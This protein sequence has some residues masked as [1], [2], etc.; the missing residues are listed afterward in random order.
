[1]ILTSSIDVGGWKEFFTGDGAPLCAPGRIFGRAS[2]LVMSGPGFRGRSCETL[3]VE[4]VPAVMRTRM[5]RSPEPETIRTAGRRTHGKRP[6]GTS[7]EFIRPDWRISFRLRVAILFRLCMRLNS[8]GSNKSSNAH[9][10]FVAQRYRL[11]AA[12]FWIHKLHKES[13]EWMS[14][15]GSCKLPASLAWSGGSLVPDSIEVLSKKPFAV[16][17]STTGHSCRSAG[18]MLRQRGKGGHQGKEANH[19]CDG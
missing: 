17:A 11:W 2:V 5:Q 13:L 6:A 16:T 3:P 19:G 12:F 4:V 14:P 8:P 1:M 9:Q 10:I 7:A 18:L 15:H